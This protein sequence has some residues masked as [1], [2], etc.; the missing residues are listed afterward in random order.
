MEIVF[1]FLK[2]EVVL[3]PKANFREAILNCIAILLYTCDLIKALRRIQT[4]I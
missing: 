3:L 1:Y 4:I 2:L